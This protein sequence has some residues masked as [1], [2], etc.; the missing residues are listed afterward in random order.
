M[1]ADRLF[2]SLREEITRIAPDNLEIS[3]IEFE[4]PMVV[5]Y[6][7]EYDKVS[8]DNKTA[9]DLAQALHKRV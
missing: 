3:S 2:D 5:V 8:G 7:K 9:R 4:G 1:N 6:T